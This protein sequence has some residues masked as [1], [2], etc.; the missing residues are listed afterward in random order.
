MT[1]INEYL[2]F[3]YMFCLLQHASVQILQRY[4]LLL[5]FLQIYLFVRF[6]IEIIIFASY[7]QLYRVLDSIAVFRKVL[8]FPRR[9]RPGCMPG[10]K[11]K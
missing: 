7:E 1:S 10:V 4:C 3:M 11:F 8:I 5:C 9:L 6:I 2:F